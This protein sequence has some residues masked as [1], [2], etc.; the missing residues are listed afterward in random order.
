MSLLFKQP[1]D[2]LTLAIVLWILLYVIVNFLPESIFLDYNNFYA[3]DVCR[4]GEQV[5]T[6]TRTVPFRF[7][8]DGVDRLWSYDAQRY[9]DRLEWSGAYQKGETVSSWK[10]TITEPAGTYYWESTSLSV[11][12]PVFMRVEIGGVRSNDFKVINCYET[13]T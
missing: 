5:L 6:G 3:S 8:A 12:L 2:Y 4:D 9:V 1:A 10:E 13:D 11:H 7:N